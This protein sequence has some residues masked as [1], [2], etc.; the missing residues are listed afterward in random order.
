MRAVLKDTIRAFIKVHPTKTVLFGY[1]LYA[2]LSWFVLQLPMCHVRSIA[3]SDHFF[4]AMSAMSTTGLA[5]ADIGTSYSFLGQAVILILIQAGGIGYMTFNTFIVLSTTNKLPSFKSSVFS[6]PEGFSVPKFIFHAVL[7]TFICELIG[8]TFLSLSF[9]ERGVPHCIWNGIFHSV[10][11]FCTAGFSLFPDSFMSFKYDLWINVLLSTLSI[12]GAVGFI[13]WIDF[14]KRLTKQ[15]DRLIFT[16]KLI[17][18]VFFGF[19]VFGTLLFCWSEGL[20]QHHQWMTAFFQVM[21]ASTTVGFNT[22]DIGSLKQTTLFLLIFLMAF[23]A[24]PSGTGGGLKYTA[25]TA[26]LGWAK[27]RIKGERVISIG[28]SIIPERR[29]Q[30]ALTAFSYYAF[31]LALS[32]SLLLFL[33]DKAFLPL[34]FESA[35]ALST[36]GLSMGITPY[37][38][39]AGKILTS[40]LMFMGKIGILT[41]GIASTSE[42]LQE[43]RTD[44]VQP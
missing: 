13:T 10:S 5:V 3:A 7:F 22:L 8:A 38:T 1:L 15:K 26:L 18:Y 33:E 25:F 21:T 23:G 36:V 14:Y 2:L 11:A 29:V 43:S 27:S 20:F 37:L 19:L 44:A 34:L 16:S 6:L 9:F 40:L 24:S 30:L 35:S 17:F 4:I 28:K 39:E 41:F 32:V 42:R 12:L 31:L